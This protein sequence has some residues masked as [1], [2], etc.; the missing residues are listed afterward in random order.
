MVNIWAEMLLARLPTRQ[1]WQIPV[2]L[3]KPARPCKGNMEHMDNRQREGYRSKNFEARQKHL[4]DSMSQSRSLS[5]TSRLPTS[6]FPVQ[7]APLHQ[8]RRGFQHARCTKG[9]INLGTSFTRLSGLAVRSWTT[10]TNG[11]YEHCCDTDA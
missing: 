8:A 5:R 1:A 3:Q 4:V 6:N 10:D 2:Q 9:S 11:F 7:R